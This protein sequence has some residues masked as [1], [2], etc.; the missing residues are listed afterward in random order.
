MSPVERA[1]FK[2]QQ[3]TKFI[4]KLI[5]QHERLIEKDYKALDELIGYKTRREVSLDGMRKKAI[6]RKAHTVDK[7]MNKRRRRHKTI[8]TMYLVDYKRITKRKKALAYK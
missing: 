7:E 6:K 4:N 3:E 5:D 1:I 2:S 8:D